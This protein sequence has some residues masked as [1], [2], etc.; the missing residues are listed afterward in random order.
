[1]HWRKAK[2]PKRARLFAAAVALLA[3]TIPASAAGPFAA[4]QAA[5]SITASNATLTG[6][7]LPNGQVTT[8]WFEW[9]IP[10]PR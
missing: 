8:V 9:G 10:P 4:T 1:M 6:M 7:A 5:T 3:G 2:L